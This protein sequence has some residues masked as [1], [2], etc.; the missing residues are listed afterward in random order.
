MY[1]SF[2]KAFRFRATLLAEKSTTWKLRSGGCLQRLQIIPPDESRAQ[3]II[4][5]S[6]IRTLVQCI[7]LSI[8][9]AKIDAESHLLIVASSIFGRVEACRGFGV[10]KVAFVAYWADVVRE[11]RSGRV[12]FGRHT[13][14]CRE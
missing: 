10:G 12:R 14:E 4:I 2:V 6:V 5:V 3:T 11:P 13:S 8:S 9:A 7:R 1:T